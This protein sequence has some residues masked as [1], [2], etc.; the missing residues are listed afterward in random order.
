MSE[1]INITKA[2]QQFTDLVREL[3]S[4]PVYV[5][6]HGKPKAVVVRYDVFETLL[7]KVEDLEDSLDA[8]T[9]REELAR[10]L[11]AATAGHKLEDYFD[12]SEPGIIRIKGHRL[13][14]EHVLE[15]FRAGYTADEIAKEFPGLSLEKI[16][17]TIT[18]YL[19]HRTEVDAYLT[20]LR[21][22][23]EREYQEWLANPSPIIKR[24]Q[25]IK[26][27]Q[28]EGNMDDWIPF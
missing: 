20:R 2:R 3:D 22:L 21:E 27:Q 8:L 9:Q 23:K 15:Y 10:D 13:G 17:A 26:A 1:I 28:V 16:H 4:E 5:T 19:C 12:F 11:E 7:E 18:Y 24:L 25:A 6:V 14:I